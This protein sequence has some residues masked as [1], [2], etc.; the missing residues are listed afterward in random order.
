[1]YLRL[2]SVIFII[3]ALL[4]LS[5]CEKEEGIGRYGMLEENT[6]EYTAVMF[7]RGIYSDDNIDRAVKLSTE[8][9]ARVLQRYHTQNNIQRHMFNL[10]YDTVEVTPQSGQSIGRTEFAEVA[11]I[12]LFFSGQYNGDTVEDLRT[13]D[14]KKVDGK[15]KVDNVQADPF[16]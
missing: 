12:T 3:V 5:G 7:I 16:L 14:L 1:M 11:V 4:H 6:P 2:S 9:M 8:K 15:W 13:L 10:K